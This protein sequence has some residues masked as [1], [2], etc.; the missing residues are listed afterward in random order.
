MFLD[1]CFCIFCLETIGNCRWAEFIVVA[2][3]Q[4]WRI[5]LDMEGNRHAVVWDWKVI[6]GDELPCD[7]V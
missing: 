4:W 1:M 3:R 2:T 7:S 6:L 5:A